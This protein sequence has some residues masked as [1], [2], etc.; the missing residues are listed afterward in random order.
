MGYELLIVF[1]LVVMD[2]CWFQTFLLLTLMTSGKLF[3]WPEW[4]EATHLQILEQGLVR[5]LQQWWG[6]SVLLSTIHVGLWPITLSPEVTMFPWLRFGR[7]ESEDR[8]SEEWEAGWVR[9]HQAVSWAPREPVSLRP[10]ARTRVE[11]PWFN[12]FIGPRGLLP[13]TVLSWHMARP[14]PMPQQLAGP[15][16]LCQW[17]SLNWWCLKD[18]ILQKMVLRCQCVM[19]ESYG[20]YILL[21]QLSSIINSQFVREHHNI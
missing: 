4:W 10:S 12:P 16:I 14:L 17:K 15:A 20:F 5:N 9:R 3:Y 7:E 18:W 8:W 13:I 2:L 21:F 19:S 11:A 6:K 1:P